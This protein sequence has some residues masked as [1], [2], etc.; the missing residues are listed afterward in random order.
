[1]LWLGAMF[2]HLEEG[3]KET[4]IIGEYPPSSLLGLW[5]LVYEFHVSVMKSYPTETP[6]SSQGRAIA[7]W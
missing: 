1:M 3:C 4:V 2:G 7:Y 5:A 6:S